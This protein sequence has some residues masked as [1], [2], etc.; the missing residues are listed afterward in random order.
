[1]SKVN[2][3][4]LNV[5]PYERSWEALYKKSCGFTP[6]FRKRYCRVDLGTFKTAAAP[7]FPPTIP[8]VMAI[9][10]IRWA[11]STAARVRGAGGCGLPEGQ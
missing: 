9:T 1:M 7:F 3:H 4:V 2:I 8:L 5:N 11:R 6:C 10:F